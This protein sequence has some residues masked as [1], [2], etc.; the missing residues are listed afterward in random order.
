MS[1]RDNTTVR[2][3]IDQ[4]KG[5]VPPFAAVDTRLITDNREK[6]VFTARQ[7]TDAHT[8]LTRG[9]A[10]YM[11]QLLFDG[12]DGRQFRFEVVAEDFEDELPAKYPACAVYSTVTA[13]YDASS[14]TPTARKENRVDG[15]DEKSPAR[16]VVKTS[17]LVLPITL[18]IWCTDKE[19]RIAIIKGLEKALCPLDWMYGIRLEL[20]H[21]FNAR[22]EYA[23]TSVTYTDT[24]ATVS[25]GFRNALIM[26]TANVP[27]MYVKE[28]PLADIRFVSSVTQNGA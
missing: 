4:S 9:L 24:S 15:Q 16:V 6:P 20:P 3:P 23:K 2:T 11:T 7:D 18:E 12:M 21:Y 8:A 13:E 10:E 22:A 27:V 28:F 19:A 17:E 26:L 5:G 1:C 14:F 25:Q